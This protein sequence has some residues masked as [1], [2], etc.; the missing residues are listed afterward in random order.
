M[1]V[2]GSIVKKRG[3]ACLHLV[4]RNRPHCSSRGGGGEPQA[5]IHHTEQAKSAQEGE[6]KMGIW[7][8]VHVT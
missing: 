6:M 8:F 2:L 5:Q 3:R 4:P 7:H 1:A